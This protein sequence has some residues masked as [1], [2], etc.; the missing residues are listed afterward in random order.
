MKYTAPVRMDISAGWPDS[1]PYRA[2]FGGKV[3]N[4]AI[5]LRVSARFE[6]I[7]LVT[8]TDDVPKS[9]GL[10]ASGALRAVYLA[11]SNPSLLDNK[12]DLIRRVHVFENQIIGHRAGFQDQA[13]AIYGGLN[14]W[15]FCSDGTIKRTPIYQKEGMHLQEHLVLV[16]T[17][18]TH[19]SINIHDLVFSARNYK[20]NIPKLDRMKKIAVKMKDNLTDEKKLTDLMAE[21]WEL[22]KSLDDSIEDN[23]MR[24][25]QRELKG[26]YLATKALG[27]GGGGCMIFYTSDRE[28]LLS[29]IEHLNKRKELKEVMVIPF[30]F[31]YEGIRAERISNLD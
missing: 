15:E 11:A 2:E 18:N 20:K 7:N 24:V 29:K 30:E 12:S 19:L 10:G 27:A 9:S 22:Q 16:Y 23:C 5:N 21:T 13:A 6:N 25:L 1:D 17:G 28:S 4:V 26:S 14:L 8:S 3:L 31:E